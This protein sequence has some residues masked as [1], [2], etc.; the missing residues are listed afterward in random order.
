MADENKQKGDFLEKLV[1]DLQ[2]MT[3]AQVDHNVHMLATDGS[4]RKRQMDV[5]LSMEAELLRDCPVRVA[6]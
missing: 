3:G 4:G 2:K 6:T 1:H 5:L